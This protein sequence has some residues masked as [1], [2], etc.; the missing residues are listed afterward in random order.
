MAQIEATSI[1]QLHAVIRGRFNFEVVLAP[2][3]KHIDM[4]GNMVR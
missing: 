4:L 1:T 3:S 2:V